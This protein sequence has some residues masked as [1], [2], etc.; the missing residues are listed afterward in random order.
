MV[1]HREPKTKKK[2]LYAYVGFWLIVSALSA[3]GRIPTPTLA[4]QAPDTSGTETL[5]VARVLATMTADVKL[6]TPTLMS[7][8][9]V[10]AQGTPTKIAATP[11]VPPSRVT[12]KPITLS[13][14]STST[15]AAQTRYAAVILR[16]P[17]NGQTVQGSAATFEWE[18]TNLQG[19]GHYEVF[20]RL[21]SSTQWDGRCKP[22]DR[23]KCILP[24]EQ[25]FGYG[26]YVWTVF[27]VDSQGK[28]V[29]QETELRKFTWREQ[30][31]TKP[32]SDAFLD[33]LE[34]G[35]SAKVL[36]LLI[37]GIVV[38]RLLVSPLS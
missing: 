14:T 38:G 26:D 4:P 24:I 33:T 19:G 12:S 28:S 18:E 37:F 8:V 16:E 22:A 29:S 34:P 32:T 15:P 31:S 25:A 11:S 30:D 7:T 3:C 6:V 10:T 20:L 35:Q 2:T 9:T 21:N 17:Q 13:S 5:I 1:S 23:K 36:L 27:I